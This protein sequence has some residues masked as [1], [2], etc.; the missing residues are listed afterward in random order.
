[1]RRSRPL[2]A[3]YP[4]VFLD[5]LPSEPTSSAWRLAELGVNSLRER[6]QRKQNVLALGINTE[7]RKEVLGM[8]LQENEGAELLDGRPQPDLKN[9]GAQDILIAQPVG[10]TGFPDALRSVFA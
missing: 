3:M 5:A 2:D 7:G 9:R 1:M 10:L 4:I 8:Y 6:T